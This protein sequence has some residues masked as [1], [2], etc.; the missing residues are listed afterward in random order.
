MVRAEVL[1]DHRRQQ[2]SCGHG[3]VCG[4]H[5]GD[6]DTTNRQPVHSTVKVAGIWIVGETTNPFYNSGTYPQTFLQFVHAW[7]QT[8]CFVLLCSAPLFG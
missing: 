5:N 8:P 7:P 6:L 4:G 3:R 1:A 2:Q